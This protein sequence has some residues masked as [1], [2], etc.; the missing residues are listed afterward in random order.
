MRVVVEPVV[1]K[2]FEDLVDQYV[3]NLIERF[4]GEVE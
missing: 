4:G 3:A 1:R 2:E